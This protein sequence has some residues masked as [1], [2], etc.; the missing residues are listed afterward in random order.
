M[1]WSIT[2][3]HLIDIEALRSHV[4]H[5]IHSRDMVS[6]GDGRFKFELDSEF[7]SL[8]TYEG[9][10]D[11]LNKNLIVFKDFTVAELFDYF[12]CHPIHVS[13]TNNYEAQRNIVNK[14]QTEFLLKKNDQL[15]YSEAL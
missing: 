4:I 13:D 5:E 15:Y 8:F 2:V 12:F 3:R 9:F 10:V 14:L 6:N 11:F 1:V 7:V